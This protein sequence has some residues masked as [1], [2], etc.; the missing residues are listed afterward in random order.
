MVNVF[1]LGSRGIPAKYGGFETFV[2]KLTEFN[3]NKN[4]KY[5]VACRSNNNDEFEYNNARCFNIKL[6]NIGAA[7]AIYYD[8]LSMKSCIKYI[9]KNS[10]ENPIIYLLGC[11]IGPFLG[12]FK[13]KLNSKGIKVFINP[14]GLEWKR[15]KW[16]YFIKKY[17]KFS[18]KSM[19]KDADLVVCD[20]KGIEEYI[21]N[22]YKKYNPRTKFIAYGADEVNNVDYLDG[23]ELQDWYNLKSVKKK[24]YYLVVGRFVPENN[25]ETM[26]REYMKSDT[27]KDFVIITN[28]EGNKFYEKLKKNTGFEKDSRIKFVGTVYNQ[29]LLTEIRKNAFAYIHGHEVGGTNPSLLESLATT[30]INLL[31][32]VNF[33]KEVGQQGALYWS[34]KEGSLSELIN[35]VDRLD[36]KSIELYSKNAKKRIK[37]YYN[38]PNI[39]NEYEKLFINEIYNLVDEEG[40]I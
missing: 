8:I 12:I 21:T 1:I 15:D 7:N 28:I 14:D 2:E 31:V 24:E 34:K 26:I 20:S 18:E 4:I 38:W 23:I 11:S 40:V 16:N 32:D 19:V 3:I 37:S 13:N 5:H 6:P 36:E 9:E 39:V 17:L 10:I 27:D 35:K 30:K 33:N 22:E 29:N 25:Y